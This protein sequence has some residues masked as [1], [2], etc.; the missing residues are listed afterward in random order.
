MYSTRWNGSFFLYL[1]ISFLSLLLRSSIYAKAREPPANPARTLIPMFLTKDILLSDA[2]KYSAQLSKI[3]IENL[4]E[5]GSVHL[6]FHEGGLLLS[7][8]D[9]VI[10]LT[11]MPENDALRILVLAGASDE[12]MEQHLSRREMRRQSLLDSAAS[13]EKKSG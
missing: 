3:M 7:H 6:T 2:D 1:R 8:V 9:D 4:I 5:H 12:Q 11:K 13:S 10:D